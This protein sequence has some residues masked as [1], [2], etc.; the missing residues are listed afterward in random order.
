MQDFFAGFG[1]IWETIGI[2]CKRESTR[3]ALSD[4]SLQTK[5]LIVPL[6]FFDFILLF[7][8]TKQEFGKAM[9]KKWSV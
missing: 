6:Q 5:S 1:G 8:K 3:C 9:K 4:V 7:L 2:G